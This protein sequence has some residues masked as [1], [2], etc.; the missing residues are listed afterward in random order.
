MKPGAWLALAIGIAAVGCSGK[1]KG[2]GELISTFADLDPTADIGK[3][4]KLEL[5][6]VIIPADVVFKKEDKQ[7]T[8]DLTGFDQT[9]EKEIYTFDSNSF[10]LSYA[11][12]D[13]YVK[14][15][16][17]LKF[18]MNV[19][20]EWKWSGTMMSGDL[21][22]A[23]TAT[24]RVSTEQILLPLSGATKSILVAVDLAIESGGPTPATRKL[25]FWFVKDKGL[26]KRQFGIGSSREPGE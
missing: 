7:L 18:P 24:V 15:L 17:L 21:P 14:P 10:N 6:K 8:I 26:V 9:Y 11:A 23:A 2:S 1:G 25:R 4:A 20:D 13:Q 22:H 12:G 16:P 3:K 5:G 19:G